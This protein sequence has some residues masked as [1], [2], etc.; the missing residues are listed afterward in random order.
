[1]VGREIRIDDRNYS[2]IVVKKLQGHAIYPILV[3]ALA[4]GMR[5][6]E[7]LALRGPTSI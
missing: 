6:G 1:M 5:R 4:A 7:P 2:A 3:V